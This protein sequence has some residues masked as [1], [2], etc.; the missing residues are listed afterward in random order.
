MPS[1]YD[2]YMGSGY[3]MP[4]EDNDKAGTDLFADHPSNATSEPPCRSPSPRPAGTSYTLG[5]VPKMTFTP[6]Q[7]DPMV[8]FLE[9]Q[10]AKLETRLRASEAHC[11]RYAVAC[12]KY[13]SAACELLGIMRQAHQNSGE[14]NVDAANDAIDSGIADIVDADA[15]IDP[16][17]TEVV[18]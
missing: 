7:P 13:R 10:I 1:Y 16:V 6:P 15:L 9:D 17:A 18:K 11:R 5:N 14:V 4:K 3:N 12:G 2:L 8:K